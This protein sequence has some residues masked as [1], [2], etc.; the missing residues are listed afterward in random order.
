VIEYDHSEVNVN[1]VTHLVNEH[2]IPNYG[3]PE[4]LIFVEWDH[5]WRADQ[6]EKA[7]KQ[8]LSSGLTHASSHVKECYRTPK[9]VTKDRDWR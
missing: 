2:I 6:L 5:V 7:I 3:K 9:Y 1:Q 8:F 4:L